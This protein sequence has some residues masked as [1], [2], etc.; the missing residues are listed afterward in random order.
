MIMSRFTVMRSQ[1]RRVRN[2]KMCACGARVQMVRGRRGKMIAEPHIC[3][4]PEL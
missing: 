3:T 2:G 1:P 4:A